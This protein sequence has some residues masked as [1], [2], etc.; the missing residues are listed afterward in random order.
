V[1][2]SG[3]ADRRALGALW[4]VALV[5]TAVMW[6]HPAWLAGGYDWR[7]FESAM[8]AARR[9]VAWFGQLPLYN[10][11]MCGGEPQLANPQSVA[12]SPAFLLVVAFG[13]AVGE[14]LMILL[15]VGVGLT[16]SFRLARALELPLWPAAATAL[17][18]GLSGWFAQHFAIGHVSFFGAALIPYAIF[19][20]LRGK[21]DLRYAIALGATMAF[22]VAQGGTST[23]AMAAIALAAVV[24]ADAIV[25]RQTRPIVVLALGALAALLLGAYRLLPAL[26]FAIDHPRRV[27][28]S[29]GQSPFL[30]LESAM[31]WAQGKLPAYRYAF[32]EYGWHVAYVC[33][34][35]AFVGLWR[36]GS[37]RR[38][39][40]A[41]VVIGST[42]AMG[43]WLHYGPWWL[44][45]KLPVLR[46]LRVPSR[47]ALL[48][49]LGVCLLAGAGLELALA[50]IAK[51]ARLM[52]LL[53][54]AAV[55]IEGSAH[56]SFYLAHA[57]DLPARATD[58][59]SVAFYQTKGHWSRML[60]LVFENHGVVGCDEEAPLTRASAID[61]GPVPQLRLA[62]PSAGTIVVHAYTPNRIELDV[63]LA[64]P[65]R[66]LVNLNWNEHWHASVGDVVRDGAK[67]PADKDGGRLAVALPQMQGSVVL[68]YRPRSFVIG[69]WLSILSTLMSVWVWR[70]GARRSAT[71]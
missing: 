65:A 39:A 32:H 56:M 35:L 71:M 31:L 28:E 64:R 34:P 25:E 23:A 1:S 63:D 21:A 18:F 54:V 61:E 53:V 67:W 46:D 14:R 70:R 43:Q 6:R 60:D 7:Y 42:I 52:S 12:G 57:F 13:T 17:A 29:D 66:L 4:L 47:Y 51:H 8:E 38:A 41:L 55:A 15:F 58:N 22:I 20:Y 2:P 11:Y 48:A 69:F 19:F 50:R 36:K 40:I 45:G 68:R 9:S 37:L 5:A 24:V 3:S 26:E 49:A 30:L 16:G 44:M 10:P 33:W 27:N 62:D 59:R